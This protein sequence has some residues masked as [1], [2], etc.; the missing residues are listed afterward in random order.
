MTYLITALLALA[1][2][3]CWGHATARTRIVVIGAT[4]GQDEA[5]FLADE[6]ARF[7]QLLAGLDLD[8]PDDPRSS[9]T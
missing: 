1:F 2:G 6:R 4:A 5:V 9:A 8:Q 3:W 7:D